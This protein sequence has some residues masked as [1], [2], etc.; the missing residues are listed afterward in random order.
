MVK[1]SILE[2]MSINELE[3]YIGPESPFVYEAIEIAYDILKKRGVN[4]SD[5]DQIRIE[6][7]IEIKKNEDLK[8]IESNTWDINAD[9]ESKGIEL[10]SQKSIWYFSIIFGIHLGAILLA[11]NL[12]SISKRKKG[13]F[14]LVFGF[15][16]S[17]FLY[18]IYIYTKI[19]VTDYYILIL[20]FALAGGASILQF[21]FWDKYLTNIKYSKKSIIIP[22]IISIVSYALILLSV[23]F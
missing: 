18:V 17:A 13:W 3:K 10:F 8:L 2:K 9:D 5:I 22:L 4:F 1:R 12:F 6:K 20:I 14:V 16:Y 7:L 19:Y 23:I 11:M 15:M 21:Y